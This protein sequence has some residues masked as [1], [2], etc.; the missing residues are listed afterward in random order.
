[1]T[2]QYNGP[3]YDEPIILPENPIK[4]VA[5]TFGRDEL[6][7][8][9][10]NVMG[11]AAIGM[12]TADPLAIAA[13]G[14]VVEKVGLFASSMREAA[15]V[16][17]TTPPDERKPRREYAAMAV[18]NGLPSFWRDLLAHD[19][20]Y[21][22]AMIYGLRS[23]PE[24]PEWMLSALTFIG[25]VGVV[26]FGDVAVTEARYQGKA[27]ALK[28]D[29]FKVDPHLEAKF[30]IND[31]DPE[32]LI[33]NLATELGL[34]PVQRS[35][36]HDRYFDSRLKTYNARVPVFRIRDRKTPE[37]VKQSRTVQV[38]YTRASHVARKKPDQFN[39]YPRNKD[40]FRKR[41]S[42]ELP[43]S[44]DDIKNEKLRRSLGK[45]AQ[46]G[47]RAQHVTYTKDYALIPGGLLVSVD[48]VDL[49]S[50]RPH[51]E[52]ELRTFRKDKT[53]VEELV[54][55]MRHIMRRYDVTQTTRSKSTLVHE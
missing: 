51:V 55:A 30:I 18:R 27:M 29:G 34:G 52:I 16:Y 5:V 25:A 37:G 48:N 21:T 53:A 40:K 54:R 28:R 22:G 23:F 32:R 7:A 35:Q 26:A 3:K 14:P 39:F 49:A 20:I 42:E 10:L 4:S 47:A 11:T 50:H 31:D 36:Y 13:T 2:E 44:I 6:A 38:I 43:E 8:L 46:R 45:I 15:E 12:A 33:T 41:L 1:M 24:T 17:R 9:G 19:P